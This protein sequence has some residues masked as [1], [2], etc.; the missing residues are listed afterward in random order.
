MNVM[1]HITPQEIVEIAYLYK[2]L[3]ESSHDLYS[4]DKRRQ[5]SGKLCL[6]M[7]FIPRYKELPKPIQEA[8]GSAEINIKRLEEKCKEIKIR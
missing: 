8:F 4:E 6:E 5:Q 2:H 7:V 1:I 3:V